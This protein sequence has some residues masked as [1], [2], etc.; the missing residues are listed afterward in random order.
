LFLDDY[1]NYML[2]TLMSVANLPQRLRILS[3]LKLVM[4]DIICSKQGTFTFQ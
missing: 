2:Q 1:A 3:S 4:P